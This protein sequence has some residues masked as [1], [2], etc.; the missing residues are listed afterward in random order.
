MYR[1]PHMTSTP[2]WMS[3]NQAK[4]K[5]VIY[6]LSQFLSWWSSPLEMAPPSVSLTHH[7][8]VTLIP[9]ISLLWSDSSPS[10]AELPPKLFPNPLAAPS[11][12]S[13]AWCQ[14][15]VFLPQQAPHLLGWGSRLWSC[16][17][18]EAKMI[19][20]KKNIRSC[21]ESHENH[22]MLSQHSLHSVYRPTSPSASL[23][24]GSSAHAM[25]L[26]FWSLN[27]LRSLLPWNFCICTL[28][29]LKSSFP[30]SLHGD[31]PDTQISADCDLWGCLSWPPSLKTPFP[32]PLYVLA[33]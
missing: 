25:W 14:T 1:T 23:P 19:F 8:G 33:S 11:I 24:L 7:P 4:T 10:P 3:K 9:S 15:P 13:P 28:P 21:Y 31:I 5:L 17:L 6:F 29:S 20:L 26:Y 32:Q 12:P 30:T 18:K 2:T 27:A 16:P 22:L